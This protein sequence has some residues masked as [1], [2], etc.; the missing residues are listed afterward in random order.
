MALTSFGVNDA[1]AVKLWSKKL[2]V[3]VLKETEIADYIGEDENSIIQIKTET[4]KSAGDKITFGLRMQLSSPGI[5]GD[6]TLE[7]NEEALTT[8]SD[9]VMIDQLRH[10]VISAGRMSEQRVPFSIRQHALDGLKDWWTDRIATSIF[11][12]LCGYTVQTDTRFTG[13]NSAIAPSSGMQIWAGGSATTDDTIGAADILTLRDIDRCVEL[14]QVMT[15][16]MRP[17]MI[18]G[19]KH[20]VLFIHPYQAFQLRQSAAAAGSWFDIQK[21]AVQGGEVTGNPIFKG[22]LGMY[23]NCIIRVDSRIPYGCDNS[24]GLV[25]QTSVRRAVF[26]GAQAA[27]IAFGK[28][29]GPGR[30]TWV[31]KKF[32]YDN[33]LGVSSA[34]IFGIVKTQFNSADFGSIVVSSYAAKHT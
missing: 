8:Y 28:D 17:V 4:T 7:G 2:D 26:C 16:A 23:N 32:D 15:P 24:T 22:A 13:L 10:A 20:W 9:Y 5:S 6:N 1:L 33:Q 19:N 27:V 14:A 30:F 34:S 11:N 25:A 31:E 12:Q 18:R 3:E 21:A 29:N